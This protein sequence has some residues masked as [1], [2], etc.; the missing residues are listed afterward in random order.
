MS[1]IATLNTPETL[2]AEKIRK[3][4]E[5]QT[6]A[7]LAALDAYGYLTD[8]DKQTK[9]ARSKIQRRINAALES[10]DDTL[11]EE[12]ITAAEKAGIVLDF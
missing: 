12:C 6:K 8:L 9:K 2:I 5:I 11:L 10:G 4:R 3:A 7:T 1:N